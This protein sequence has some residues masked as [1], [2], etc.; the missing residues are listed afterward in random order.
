MA[1]DTTE[2]IDAQ[3]TATL[4]DFSNS[5][6][7]QVPGSSLTNRLTQCRARPTHRKNQI[8]LKYILNHAA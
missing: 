7:T 3:A 4:V 8:K 5:V 1:S 6:L 2:A